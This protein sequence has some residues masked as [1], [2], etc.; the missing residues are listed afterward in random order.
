MLSSH[1]ISWLVGIGYGLGFAAARKA[2]MN[3][4]LRS[5]EIRYSPSRLDLGLAGFD[6]DMR[7]K[8]ELRTQA[9]TVRLCLQ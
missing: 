7:Q 6:L 5:G 2:R 8:S 3:T 9:K 1:H 4:G